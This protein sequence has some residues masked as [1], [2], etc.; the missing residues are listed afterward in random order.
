[1]LL[2]SRS[3]PHILLN[4]L[5]ATCIGPPAL[6]RLTHDEFLFLI[7]HRERFLII[8]PSVGYIDIFYTVQIVI[9]HVHVS[10]IASNEKLPYP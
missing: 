5:N 1:M 7:T 8:L 9:Y 6:S 4:K 10:S 3:I 2:L